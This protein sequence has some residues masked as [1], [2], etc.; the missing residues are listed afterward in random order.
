[1][2][3]QQIGCA[4]PGRAGLQSTAPRLFAASIVVF[5]C[6]VLAG[7][8]WNIPILKAPQPGFA[9]MMPITAVGFI[10]AG[11]ALGFATI[12]KRTAQA[13]G[14]SLA[15]ALSLLGLQSIAEPLLGSP[16]R[17]LLFRSAPNG[18]SQWPITMSLAAALAFTLFGL[19]LLFAQS[20]TRRAHF[21]FVV[22]ATAGL[23]ISGSSLLG[24]MFDAKLLLG[25]FLQ[26]IAV[27]SAAAFAGLFTALFAWRSDVGWARVLAGDSP[28]SR[29]VRT[30]FALVILLPVLCAWLSLRGWEGQLYD[31]E[32][33][34]TAFMLLTIVLWAA[35]VLASGFRLR[36]AEQRQLEANAALLE[37]EAKFRHMAEHA[38]GMV[39]VTNADAC[40][41]FLS[42][43][44]C[45]F[46]G[47]QESEALDMHWLDALHPADRERARTAFLNANAGRASLQCEHRLLRSDG[48]VRWMMN[49]AN[50]WFGP[51][52]AFL[53]YIGS[54]VDITERRALE[55]QLR[56]QAELLNQTH[57]AVILW[58]WRDG[59]RYWN[60]GALNLYGY[61]SAE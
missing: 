15:V 52:G 49:T 42:A 20:R 58:S 54:F 10:A 14:I 9:P 24:Y 34:V 44:W 18:P 38:P 51:D 55:Q 29:S 41:T 46:T 25:G 56:T 4:L 48:E 12:R 23:L 33:A 61:T 3:E 35:L 50:P 47:Q 57:D 36:R 21:P 40:C 1:M 27:Y 7:W 6:A 39:W 37:S 31:A 45:T 5:G 16:L 32:S 2:S 19:S 8:R 11:V 30:L 28:A 43:S 59:V 26:T 13:L 60:A 22:F 17:G 53:G